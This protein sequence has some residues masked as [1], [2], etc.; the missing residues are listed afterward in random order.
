[1]WALYKTLEKGIPNPVPDSPLKFV[2]ALFAMLSP[3]I[4][5][6]ALYIMYPQRPKVDNGISLLLYILT[7]FEENRFI[8]FARL[9]QRIDS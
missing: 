8:E 6:D 5:W 1:M 2:Q 4:I 3:R 9:Q 7:G